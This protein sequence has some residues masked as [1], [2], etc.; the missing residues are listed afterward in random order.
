MKACGIKEY[1]GRDKIECMALPDPAPGDGEVRIAI[2]AAGVNPVDY[3]IREG[4]LAERMPSELPIVLGWDAAGVIDAVGTG[5]SRLKEGDE[6]YAYCRLDTIHDGAYAEYIVLPESSVALK[7]K[8]LSFEEAA[9]V[10]LAALTAYQALFDA[11]DVQSGETVLVHAAAGGVGGFAVQFA[12]NHGCRVFG[13]A[14]AANH[15]YVKGL[16]ADEAIDYRAEDFRDAVRGLAS[17]GVDLAFDCVGGEVLEKTPDIL[18]QP[19]GRMITIVDGAR[20]GEMKEQ[21]INA[22]WIFV[23]PNAEQLAGMADMFESGTIK[24]RVAAVLPMSDAAKAHE[25]LESRHT[26]GKV[27]L[28]P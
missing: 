25:M 7:P 14:S 8:N 1:G 27:V 13:T 9:G 5:V 26:A 24:T 6:V 18:K 20:A 4:L 12:K 17:D 28:V 2:K 15:E 23:A 22:G 11:G 21:G 3:K 10:P 19:D 16:G